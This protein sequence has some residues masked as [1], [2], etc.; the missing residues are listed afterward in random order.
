[1]LYTKIKCNIICKIIIVNKI[2]LMIFLNLNVS[3]NKK[4][5][6]IQ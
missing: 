4:L 5:L 1:M 6:L 2:R 3:K